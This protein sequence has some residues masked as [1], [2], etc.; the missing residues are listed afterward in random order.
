MG[1]QQ[2]NGEYIFYSEMSGGELYG[3]RKWG[4]MQIK[5]KVSLQEFHDTRDLQCV[6]FQTQGL[7]IKPQA[8]T[9]K[10]GKQD[11]G[12]G[13]DFTSFRDQHLLVPAKLEL[14]VW[15]GGAEIVCSGA[16]CICD[17]FFGEIHGKFLINPRHGSS[18]T[19]QLS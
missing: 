16:P 14:A 11:G 17:L 12:Q 18:A 4:T 10:L 1:C 19:V 15:A 13:L 3:K 2:K 8:K 6:L 5:E 7:I 9:Q